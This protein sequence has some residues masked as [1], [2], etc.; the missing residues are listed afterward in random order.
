LNA[1][2]KLDFFQVQL[3]FAFTVRPSVASRYETDKKQD[4]EFLVFYE[5]EVLL[6]LF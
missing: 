3:M 4:E 2:L 5:V 6:L 1:P